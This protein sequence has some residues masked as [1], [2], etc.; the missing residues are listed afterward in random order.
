MDDGPLVT[1]EQVERSLR[2][3]VELEGAIHEAGAAI[4]EPSKPAYGT[5]LL[6]ARLGLIGMAAELVS[7][8][9]GVPGSTT[10]ALSERL[11]LVV[12]ALQ[13]VSVTE[14]LISEGQYI[15][16][17]GAPRP[18]DP[19]TNAGNRRRRGQDRQGVQ[20]KHGPLGRG[21]SM[22]TSAASRMSLSPMSSMA[23]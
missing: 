8:R 23:C 22:A 10:Q 16:A 6:D 5:V 21:P 12:A 1:A 3:S 13:G 20:I 17:A 15:K 14:T 4:L 7:L 2:A 19:R 11:A 9:A 18:R